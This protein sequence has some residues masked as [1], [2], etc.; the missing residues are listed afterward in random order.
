MS[1]I[2][3]E[4]HII[5]RKETFTR[6]DYDSL[7]PEE[8]DRYGN[9]ILLCKNDHKL[10]DDQPAQYTVEHLRQIKTEHEEHI[11]ANW[12]SNEDRHQQDD[13]T[14]ASYIDEWVTRSDLDH[15]DV[16]SSWLASGDAPM[17]AKA[18]Y[19]SARDV[20]PW[21]LSRIWPGRYRRLEDALVNYRHVLRDMLGVF[22]RHVDPDYHA[23]EWLCTR[24]FYQIDE[25]DQAR[26]SALAKKYD[27]HVTLVCDLFLELTRAANYVC[28]YVRE[29]LFRGFRLQEGALLV[30]R[31]SGGFELKTEYLRPEYRGDE[32]IEKPYPGLKG[33][34]K[35]RYTRDVF[36]NPNE[37]EPPAMGEELS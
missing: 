25:W 6:G 32:R 31:D 37:P 16:I 12:G 20:G 33:F 26:Y 28:D 11:R 15:W 21:L 19:D 13:E 22:N 23:A 3:D 14:Y 7:A 29:C 36:I 27:D 5:A 9:L 10:I 18:W 2:G 4:A 8:R 1:V 35:A 30:V 24:K 17:V 34:L